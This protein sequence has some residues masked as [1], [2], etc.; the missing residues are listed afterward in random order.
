[1]ALDFAKP[2]RIAIPPEFVHLNRWHEIL[3]A[4]PSAAA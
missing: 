2:A 1:V 3:K 4:R